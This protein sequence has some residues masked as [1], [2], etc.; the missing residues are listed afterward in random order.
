MT[1]ADRRHLEEVASKLFQF[2]QSHPE[3]GIEKRPDTPATPVIGPRLI[4]R[5][6]QGTEQAAL[7]I[8]EFQGTY[9]SKKTRVAVDRILDGSRKRACALPA[10]LELAVTGSA[11]VGHDI[12]AAANESIK[13]TTYTTIGLV[14]LI[15][16]VVYR[17][18]LLA[19]IPWSRSRSR[20][21]SRWS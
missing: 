8:V 17:S 16:L 10:G 13:N 12:N 1:P 15:L 11:V 2:A 3:L 4:G 14:V 21:S 9:L 18:P 20:C 7:M 5:N 19:M 6:A